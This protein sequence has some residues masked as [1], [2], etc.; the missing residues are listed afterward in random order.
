[1][2]SDR[3]L[4]TYDSKILI[5]NYQ[6]KHDPDFLPTFSFQEDPNDP[7]TNDVVKLCENDY[8]CR[9]DAFTTRSLWI[10]NATKLIHD[11]HKKLLQVLQP[12]RT[13]RIT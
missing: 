4:F 2:T 3:S 13:L 12:G 7:F 1:M 5:D 6:V 10:G 9:F 11:N 8:F